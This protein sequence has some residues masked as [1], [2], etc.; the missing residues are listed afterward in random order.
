MFRSRK[1][2]KTSPDNL[3]I[4]D[5][6]RWRR[7]VRRCFASMAYQSRNE[8]CDASG[9]DAMA[10]QPHDQTNRHASVGKFFNAGAHWTSQQCGR[11]S[12][13]IFACATVVV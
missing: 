5:L 13:F 4:I 1:A 12:T 9:R 8:A 7:S 11:P 6:S 2:Y 3:W 10:E